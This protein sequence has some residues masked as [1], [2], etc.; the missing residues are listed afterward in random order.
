M[1][2]F[3]LDTQENIFCL[4]L[5]LTL[6]LFDNMKTQKPGSVA[7]REA[8]ILLSCFSLVLLLDEWGGIECMRLLSCF[9]WVILLNGWGESN[10]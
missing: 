5:S 7:F 8:E 3:V 2:C 4:S 1:T 6:I 9:S 10:A